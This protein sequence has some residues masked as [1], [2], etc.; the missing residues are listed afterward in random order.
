MVLYTQTLPLGLGRH[1][2]DVRAIDL[3]DPSS[4]RVLSAGGIS[5]PWTLCFAKIS[6]LLLYKRIFPLRREV[7]AS[8]I[9]I[10]ADAVM[11]AFCI[12]IAIGSIVKCAGLQSGADSYCRFNAGPMVI[13][14]SVVNVT[15]DIYVLILPI[16]RLLH[17]QVDRWRKIGLLM[18]F[19][20]G[21]G[22]CAAS[23][24]RLINFSINYHSTDTFWIQGRNAEF[25]IVEMNVAIIVACATSLPVFFTQLRSLGSSFY[26]SA[27]SLLHITQGTKRSSV[28]ASGESRHSRGNA[29]YHSLERLKGGQ[30]V[31][32]NENG[33][34]RGD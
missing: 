1:M 19:A 30:R 14:V 24:A 2:W 31:N 25:S 18:V 29:G 12:G 8:W 16:P 4:N 17:L 9:G 23:L 27:V 10:V 6:I 21:L 26:N 32:E 11:Y 5:F 22:A 33:N 7:I 15:T 3:L 13:I 28:A 20:S 34:R